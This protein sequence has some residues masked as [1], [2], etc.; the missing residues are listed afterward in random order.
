MRASRQ[1]PA[2]A[3]LLAIAA[4][5]LQAFAGDAPKAGPGKGK[6]DLSCVVNVFKDAGGSSPIAS[7]SD[8]SYADAKA[9]FHVRVTATNAGGAKAVDYTVHA[10]LFHGPERADFYGSFHKQEFEIAA[11]QSKDFETIAFPFGPRSDKFRI[12]AKLD[13]AN[14]VDESN[15][16][17]NSCEIVFSTTKLGTPPAK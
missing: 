6:P 8:A 2:W 3:F 4:T 7:G 17:N 9:K 1:L 14:T 15:E 12:T 5:G 13:K 16:T 10:T 11:G